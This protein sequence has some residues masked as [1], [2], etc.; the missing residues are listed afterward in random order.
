MRSRRGRERAWMRSVVSSVT[1]ALAVVV[2][3]ATTVE[4]RIARYEVN[5]DDRSLIL[6]REPFG[7]ERG[8][9]MEIA[10][11]EPRV[12]L[13]EHAPPL[14]KT[15]LGFV[16]TEARDEGALDAALEDGA[17]AA[18]ERFFLEPRSSNAPANP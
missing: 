15:R 3:A 5:K 12:Y 2:L 17:A 1:C 9:T 8:G 6:M 4:G 16:I 7:F 10:L 14:D 11:R 13:P 18:L